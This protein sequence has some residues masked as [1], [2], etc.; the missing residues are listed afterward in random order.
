MINFW[1]LLKGADKTLKKA[2]PVTSFFESLSGHVPLS[3]SD[4]SAEEAAFTFL[5]FL[6]PL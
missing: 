6:R 2:V 4:G 1:I 3:F 5:S